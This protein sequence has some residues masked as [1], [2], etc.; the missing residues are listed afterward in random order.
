[1]LEIKNKNTPVAMGKLQY[2]LL[3]HCASNN[4][5]S[6]RQTPPV[7]NKQWPLWISYYLI[8]LLYYII[9]RIFKKMFMVYLKFCMCILI[10]TKIHSDR[11]KATTCPVIWLRT[12]TF[13]NA[14][15]I[16]CNVVVGSLNL[17]NI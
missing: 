11:M 12:N 6:S 4:P 13:D 9:L 2:T 8:Y 5:S 7:N 15:I 10:G 1:M 3:A 16:C 14:I 17:L